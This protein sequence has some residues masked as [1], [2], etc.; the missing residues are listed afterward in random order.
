MYRT[1]VSVSFSAFQHT[2]FCILKYTKNKTIVIANYGFQ[3][4]FLTTYTNICAWMHTQIYTHT[5]SQ[6]HKYTHIHTHT[7]THT[8]IYIYI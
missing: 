1:T 6:R 7:H 8:H 5:H 4:L 3:L 2:S